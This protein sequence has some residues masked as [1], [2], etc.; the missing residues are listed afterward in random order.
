MISGIRRTYFN[1]VKNPTSK[2][3][4]ILVNIYSLIIP[5]FQY[6]NLQISYRVTQQAILNRWKKIISETVNIISAKNL[7][8]VLK[9]CS[10]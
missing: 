7:D 1:S 10:F 5:V 4:E 3:I 6:G 9:F 2:Y 8:C